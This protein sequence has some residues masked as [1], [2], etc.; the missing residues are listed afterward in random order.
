M[1]DPILLGDEIARALGVREG[2]SLHAPGAGGG[3]PEVLRMSPSQGRAIFVPVE[4]GDA[5]GAKRPAFLRLR[6][7]SGEAVG[8]GAFESWR[9]EHRWLRGALTPLAASLRPLPGVEGPGAGAGGSVLPPL[10]YCREKKVWIGA[11]CVECEKDVPD[12]EAGARCASCGRTRTAGTRPVEPMTSLERIARRLA[13]HRA[14]GA[15]AGAAPVAWL[16]CATCP[17]RSACFPSKEAGALAVE[18][19]VPLVDAPS[20]A[21]LVEPFDLPLRAWLRLATG[22]RWSA[23]RK[24]L[25]SW[26]AS[27]V[28]RLDGVFGP[29]RPTLLGP[30]HGPL[31]ALETLLLRLEILRQLLEGL[32][33]LAAGPGRPHLGLAPDAI[34][35]G[36][37][38][39][40]VW[41]SPLWTSRARILDVSRA[42]G[43]SVDDLAP[44]ADRPPALVSA[45]CRPSAWTQGRCLPRAAGGNFTGMKSWDFH[46]LPHPSTDKVPSRGTRVVFAADQGGRPVGPMIEGLIDVAF[47]D[48]W[49][50]G[51]PEPARFEASLRELIARDEG[52]PL[53]V[54]RPVTEHG[55][56]DDLFAI[57]TLWLASLTVD[58]GGLDLAVALRDALRDR[59]AKAP[60][61]YVAAAKG[62]GF[63]LYQAQED[64]S[65]RS[66]PAEILESILDL[67]NRLCGGVPGAWPGQSH[68][69]VD[70][71]RRKQVLR[72]F[73]SEVEALAR[74]VRH[75]IFGFS[76][77]DAEIR[78]ALE[79]LV[80]EG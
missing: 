30:E 7:L 49:M 34:A 46:F 8:E 41:G 24:E 60:G 18:R 19:L 62:L 42:A 38:A 59:G 58:P 2:L 75:R 15:G 28:L 20:G 39:P 73:V 17:E 57:G 37:A 45:D 71:A 12:A 23:V 13:A 78:A 27:H 67:G 25:S 65:E 26:P 64:G 4:I 36:L 6:P 44:P 29:G 51:V 3:G 11:I 61:G 48:V 21:L 74:V 63:V 55:L 53:F 66:L 33:A 1:P 40:D 70:P 5:G 35:I 52:R 43:E 54:M 47:S 69:P 22:E 31:F 72:D 16:P 80:R 68:E 14:K 77:E 56:L 79:S 50:V 9:F 32:S 76:A 10:L